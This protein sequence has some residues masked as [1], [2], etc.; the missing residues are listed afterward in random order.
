M[1]PSILAAMLAKQQGPI[2]SGGAG[3]TVQQSD[4]AS[5]YDTTV[6]IRFN[7]NGTVE[8][9]EVLNGGAFVWTAA[10][11]WIDP[12]ASADGTYDVRF[13][14]LVVNSG[15]GDWTTEAAVD[16][17]WIALSAQRIWLM[18]STTPIENDFDCDFEVRKSAGPPPATGGTA[19]TFNINNFF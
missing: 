17:A 5:P 2:L 8:T 6:G 19:W 1:R 7:T 9:V 11:N 4:G 10:G 3:G 18:N 16:D 14:N 13:T 12:A 15:S